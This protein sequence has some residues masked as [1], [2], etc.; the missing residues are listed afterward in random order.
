[1]SA[2]E[3]CILAATGQQVIIA[4][5]F[6]EVGGSGSQLIGSLVRLNGYPSLG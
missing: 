2:H 4:T 6:Y 1:M 3:A 5:T